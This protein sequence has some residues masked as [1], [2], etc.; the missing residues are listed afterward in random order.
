MERGQVCSFV[1]GCASRRDRAQKTAHLTPLWRAL[2][3]FLPEAVTGEVLLFALAQFRQRTAGTD[4]RAGRENRVD[5]RDRRDIRSCKE[6]AADRGD[7]MAVAMHGDRRG[8]PV[9]D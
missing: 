6:R 7:Q 8:R 2:A 3:P 5:E 1:T 4:L 9:R